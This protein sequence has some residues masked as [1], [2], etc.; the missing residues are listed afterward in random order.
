MLGTTHFVFAGRTPGRGLLWRLGLV[1]RFLRI[2]LRVPGA[3]TYLECLHLAEAAFGTDA[4]GAMVEVGAFKG[5]STCCL[6]L[7]AA[8]RGMR[9]IVVDTFA[10][11]PESDGPYQVAT[12]RER[13]YTFHKG[14]YAASFEELARNLLTFGAAQC[15]E[16][17]SGDVVNLTTLPLQPGGKVSFAFLDVDLLQ[18]YMGSLRLL[19]RYFAPG[20]RVLL[21]EGLLEPIKQMQEN[22]QFWTELGL[23]KPKVTYFALSAGFRTSLSQLEI[24]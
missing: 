20:A 11:L 10:G 9:L 6:S 15:V 17:V 22:P 2:H 8:T 7:V 12:D 1:F 4:S 23:E 3:V 18:S 21:H 13:S 14:E 19:S 16:A 5:R 24:R